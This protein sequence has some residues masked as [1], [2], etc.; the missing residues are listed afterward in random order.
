MAMAQKADKKKGKEQEVFLGV[1]GNAQARA[2]AAAASPPPCCAACCSLQLRTNALA[3]LWQPACTVVHLP[4]GLR[5]VL[6]YWPL[7]RS[8]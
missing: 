5:C 3:M 8:P 2:A 4:A 6:V 1:K 7:H